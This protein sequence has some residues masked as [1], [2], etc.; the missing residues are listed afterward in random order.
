MV[1][2]RY[3]CELSNYINNKNISDIQLTKKEY[4][5][6]P[7]NSGTAE[8]NCRKHIT[9]PEAIRLLREFEKSPYT[10][11]AKEMMYDFY[12]KVGMD[13]DWDEIFAD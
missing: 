4:V 9:D 12:K 6:M 3:G 7:C 1:D 5:D 2:V 10:P 11:S 8:Y 13:V